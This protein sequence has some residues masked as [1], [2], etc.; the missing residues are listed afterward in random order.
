GHSLGEAHL[1]FGC[2]HPEKDFLYKNEL[3]NAVDKGLITLHTA[4]SRIEGKGKVYV[5]DRLGEDA[6]TVLSL[7]ESGG[8]LYICGDGSNMAPAVIE[9]IIKSYQHKHDTTYENAVEWIEN[10]ELEGRLAKDVW[11]GA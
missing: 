5:Q 4:F 2:R 10:L 11:A 9:K 7:L 8:C 1:Y 6:S 3:E